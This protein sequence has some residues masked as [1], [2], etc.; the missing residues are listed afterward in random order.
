MLHILCPWPVKQNN[1]FKI[2][3]V[4]R[5]CAYMW[6]RRKSSDRNPRFRHRLFKTKFSNGK[7]QQ[8]GGHW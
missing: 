2:L 8:V 1:V 4:W 7:G 6:P 5:P 3:F